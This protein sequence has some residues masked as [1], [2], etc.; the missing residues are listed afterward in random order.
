MLAYTNSVFVQ[1][2]RPMITDHWVTEIAE[3]Q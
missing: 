2:E 1:S 3:V